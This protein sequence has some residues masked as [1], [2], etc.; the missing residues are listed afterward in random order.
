MFNVIFIRSLAPKVLPGSLIDL[1]A[2]WD[3][4]PQVH[5]RVSKINFVIWLFGGTLSISH[6]KSPKDGK[7]FPT[8]DVDQMYCMH[9]QLT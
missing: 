4:A 2:G 9:L 5:S 3:Y 7:F 8:R 6:E 1:I